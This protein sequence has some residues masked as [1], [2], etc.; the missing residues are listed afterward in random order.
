[1]SYIKHNKEAWEEAFENR[2]ESWGTDVVARLLSEETPFLEGELVK[3]LRTLDFEGKTIGQFCCN[4]GRELLSMMKLGAKAGF[5]F[6]I[7]QNMID[8]ANALAKQAS[9]NATFVQANILDIPK[10]YDNQFDYLLIAIGVL[11]WFEDLDAFFKKAVSCLKPNGTLII[12]EI[13]PVT[14]MIATPHESLF[15]IEHPKNIVYSYFRSE[16]WIE[17][18]GVGYMNHDQ[19]QSKTF[20]SYSHTLGR[21]ITSICQQGLMIKQLNEFEKDVSSQFNHV[22]HQGIPLSYILIAEKSATL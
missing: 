12:H 10:N 18:S 3:E 21:I 16:P 7:A 9:I 5:G 6:D 13:H 8:E 19:T 1:M 11:T 15:D 4:N 20:V 17:N 22:S 14:G 2:K